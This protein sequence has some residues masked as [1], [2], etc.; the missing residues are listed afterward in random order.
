MA[1]VSIFFNFTDN[2]TDN[3]YIDALDLNNS[4]EIL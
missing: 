4:N 1:I 3:V 2:D